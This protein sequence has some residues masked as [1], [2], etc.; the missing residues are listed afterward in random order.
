M[1]ITGGI[2]ILVSSILRWIDFPF[3]QDPS[4][5]QLPLLRNIGLTPHLNVLSYGALAIAALILS[6]VLL[7]FSYRP[8]A[9]AAAIL[10]TLSAVAPFQVTFQRPAI[11][12]R[13]IAESA[14]TS[15][16]REFTKEYLPENYGALEDIPQ[17]LNLS[18]A[19]SRAVAAYS[20]IGLGWY[21]FVSGS[22]LI[23]AYSISRLP[24]KKTPTIMALIFIPAGACIILLARPLVAQHYFSTAATAQAQGHN[25]KAI[26]SYR[27]AM[28]WDRWHK[29]N[30]D[31]YAIIG[32]LERQSGVAGDSPERHVSKA[33]EFRE[34]NQ[35]DQAIFELSQAAE[36]GGP[37]TAAARR[38]SA[39][40]RMYLGLAF[41][42]RGGV[43]AAVTQWEQAMLE[44]PLQLYTLVC[45]ARANYDLSRYQA[46]L[47]AVERV[48]K[49]GGQV[50]VLADAYSLG[51][52]CYAKLGQDD[53][54]RRYY[55]HSLK[56]D[57]SENYWAL[58]GLVGQ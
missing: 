29:Q 50:S 12:R 18:T 43:G 21:L 8:V 1:L 3:S 41:Y 35:Y 57:K 38:E 47:A 23:A 16:I 44:D 2:L 56:L 40:A 39:R 13:L 37:L 54:A 26:V 20:F 9:V 55:V 33:Q 25:E 46:A 7:R 32:D 51:G 45:L 52:D 27:A 34:Q 48:L 58:T 22:L 31:V 5:L 15:L 49:V 36:A 42:H 17:R 11:L 14:G 28:R 24:A 10:L 4:G 19:W 6:T 30:I 53:E